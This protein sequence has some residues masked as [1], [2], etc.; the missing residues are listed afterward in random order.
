M[1]TY[2]KNTF[3]P[4]LTLIFFSV[5]PVDLLAAAAA[6]SVM[7]VRESG[8]PLYAQQDLESEPLGQLQKGET[9]SPIAE[10]VAQEI[11]YMVRTQ[12]GQI[13]WVRAVDVTASSETKNSFKEK[14]TGSSTWA[15]RSEDGRTFAGNWSVTPE[16]TTRSARGFWTMRDANGATVMSGSWSAAMHTTGWNGTWRAIAEGRQGELGGSWSADT[17]QTKK[18]NFSE[19]FEAAV[20]EA[21][22]GL[23]TAGGDSGSWT[24][25]TYK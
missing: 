25:R 23:W 5:S 17:E 2:F 18:N 15:A 3:W 12:Q 14:E 10:S 11:W 13:G 22:R 24:I 7:I 8:T 9:L 20:K 19:M 6:P 16:S 1:S 21:V 4:L